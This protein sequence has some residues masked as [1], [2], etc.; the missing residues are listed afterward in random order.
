ML[1]EYRKFSIFTS[2]RLPNFT[3]NRAAVLIFSLYFVIGLIIVKD[4]G[5]S[6]DETTERT[7]SLANYVYVM[8]KEMR[9]SKSESVKNT[10]NK[11]PDLM[12]Y[13][14][15]FYGAALQDVTVFIEHLFKFELPLRDVF[16]LRHIFTFLNYFAAGVFFY[17]ILKR[18]FGNSFIP[19]LGVL[20]YILYPRFFGES[21][22]NIKDI[23]FFSWYVISLYF[24][25]RWLED[26]R[27]H[28]LLPAA[29]TI[30]IAANTR[31]LGISVLLLSCVFAIAIG[32]RKK[33]DF[34]QAIQK[35]LMLMALAFVC[36]VIITPFTWENPL[37][38]TLDTFL[39][40]IDR[41][42][43]HE[44]HL[45]MGEMFTLKVPWHYIP[46]WMGLTIPLLY[47]VMFFVGTMRKP[48]HLFDVFFVTLFF[49]TLF[50]FIGFISI[51][52]GWRHAYCI[53]GSFLYIAV[54]GLE[55]SFAFLQN[56]RIA[57][58]RGFACIVAACMAYLFAWNVVNHP[59]QY[60]YFNI[61]GKQFAEKNFILDLWDVSFN[62]MVRKVLANDDRPKIKFALEGVWSKE[63]MLTSDEKKRIVWSNVKA[64]YYFQDSRM[65]YKNRAHHPGFTEQYAV[66]VDGM[67]ISA[68]FK[69]VEPSGNFDNNAWNKIERFESNVDNNFDEMCDE[70]YDTE[71]ST[72]KPQQSGDYIMFEF[73]EDV[74]Y[75]YLFLDLSHWISGDY[76][77]DLHIYV[78]EDGNAW[79]TVSTS[80][81]AQVYYKLE[82]EP[83]RFLKLENKGFDDRFSWS[84]SE[85]KFGYA[86][87]FQQ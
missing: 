64:D 73:E 23:M 65:L 62:D 35:P 7:T 51:G 36:Y 69:H 72:N 40:F 68:M 6:T 80:V 61:V 34:L 47:I 25:L 78:S 59:Y 28:F 82:T 4:Y 5:I 31:I 27:N 43:S 63:A 12:T 55:R 20:L 75:N 10:A 50:G 45:Y 13:I 44:M 22:Y 11:A 52:G 49:C 41:K 86:T 57:F 54:L 38:N 85:M 29:A 16:L 37:K 1:F 17:L 71:W 60:V 2:M 76:P 48:A 70:D 58:R 30:A 21:F 53:Y 32:M 18:R 14:D 24:A 77:R 3:L 67:K 84:I 39:H 9:S 42:P 15:R 33:Q 56:K 19:L 87:P 46:V 8:G 26:E 74:S 66:I 81:T 83:Y 79:Q